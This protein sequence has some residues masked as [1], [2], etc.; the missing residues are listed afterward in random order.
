MAKTFDQV[1]TQAR[2]RAKMIN[3]DFITHEEEDFTINDCC[4]ELYHDL[5]TD[6][7]RYYIKIPPREFTLA[8]S[9]E[10]ASLPSDFYKCIGVDIQV[11][12]EWSTL[13]PFNWIE[14][15]RNNARHSNVVVPHKS[16]GRFQ[17]VGRKIF[18]SPKI[19]GTYRL[20]YVPDFEDLV[21]GS[22]ELDPELSRFWR[23]IYLNAAISYLHDEESDTSDLLTELKLSM[24]KLADYKSNR[25]EQGGQVGLEEHAVYED[26]RRW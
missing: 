21:V 1:K 20:W 26:V 6:F 7:E 8:E 19:V 11:G 9:D 5:V 12:S 18:I 14:R 10:Y 25:V 13:D 23:I 17:I 15:N 4:R 16:R 3:S 22:E 24:M 2:H